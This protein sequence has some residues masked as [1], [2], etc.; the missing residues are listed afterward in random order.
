PDRGDKIRSHHILAALAELAPVHVGCFAE[1]EADLAAVGELRTVAASHCLPLRRKPLLW[2]GL[3]ALGRREPV[4]VA[5][6]RHEGLRSW[7]ADTL[8][9][10]PIDTIYVF[11]GQMGRYV[12]RGWSG[13]LVVDLVDVDSAKFEAY[14]AGG[15][16]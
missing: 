9:R 10:H 1:S 12:P 15:T 3:E 11:S 13:R 8:R 4:S 6:F 7:V 2:A 14:A 5:A 16:W